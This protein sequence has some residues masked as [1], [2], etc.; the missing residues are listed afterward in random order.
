M[1]LSTYRAFRKPLMIVASV[2]KCGYNE[3]REA[4]IRFY[5]GAFHYIITDGYKYLG[6][7]RRLGKN[8]KSAL[9]IV[10]GYLKQA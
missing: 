10:E 7:E 1:K 8:L 5:D 6:I 2:G 3:Y 4:Q 9:N